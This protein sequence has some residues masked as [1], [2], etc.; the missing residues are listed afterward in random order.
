MSREVSSRDQSVTRTQ[1]PVRAQPD[2]S[3]LS[4]EDR[5]VVRR[6]L[7][8]T[9]EQKPIAAKGMQQHWISA[10]PNVQMA[11]PGTR[12]TY[13]VMIGPEISASD[14]YYTY[15][16]TCYNDPV[17]SKAIGA[18]AVVTGP[19]TPQWSATWAFPGRHR[20]VC[21]VQFHA[22]QEGS[23]GRF[24]DSVP[25]YIEYQQAVRAESNLLTEEMA[26][27]PDLG[28]PGD[29]LRLL[30]GFSD[31]LRSAEAQP[32]SAPVD[33]GTREGLDRQIAGLSEKL[34]SSE[35]KTRYP[36]SAVHV[37]SENAAVSRLNVFLARTSAKPGDE[38]WVLVD[39]TNPTD[40]RLTGEYTGTGKNAREA[41]QRAIERWDGDNRYPAGLLRVEVPG[42][43]GV[44]LEEEFRTDGSS[45]WDSIADFFNQVGLWAGVTSLA[46]AVVLSVAPEPALSKAAAVALWTA[47]LA[48]TTA[49]SIDL[50]QRHAE[51][52]S[53][54]MEDALDAVMIVGN[55]LGARCLLGATVRGLSLQGTRMGTA[56][57]IGR[58]GTDAAQGILL[59]A[60]YLGEYQ[61]ISREPD[62]KRRTDRLISLLQR[63]ATTGG[64][65]ILSM[66]GNKADLDALGAT[67]VDLTQ[68][69]DPAKCIDIPP[70]QKPP[71][72]E[73]PK[74]PTVEPPKPPTVEP[75]KTPD[76]E[77]AIEPRPDVTSRQIHPPDGP[78]PAAPT[79]EAPPRM[80]PIVEAPSAKLPRKINSA[81][82]SKDPSK[83]VY[84]VK[85]LS[86]D[87]ATMAE[88]RAAERLASEGHDVHFRDGFKQTDLVVDGELVDVKHL[89]QTSIKSA[90]HRAHKQY[91]TTVYID[92]T[93]IGLTRAQ[94]QEAIGEMNRIA[95]IHPGPMANVKRLIIVLSD[96]SYYIHTR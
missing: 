19:R 35:G 15:E 30:Q 83:T 5:A 53:T 6:L 22:K 28:E 52:M 64:L 58:F 75:V 50:L 9:A 51:G 33:P 11:V 31:A 96:N 21:R 62:R 80:A 23:P 89:D 79:D 68:L 18:L 85:K 16:W 86:T 72:V 56:V 10:T 48:G 25:E 63:A 87:P 40:R 45:S 67:K 20:V 60:E 29:Q 14:S 78:K 84:E 32:G 47:I 42:S 49:T 71:M 69:G 57:V 93:T 36:V 38:T 73:P 70:S 59:S 26:H 92:G 17:T 13:A 4:A 61:E 44:A 2:V 34:E 77:A 76:G 3:P 66:R 81:R 90:V 8:P 7:R 82:S 1:G 37:A 88:V 24:E 41:I 46:A 39:I 27:A 43:A 91:S 54:P 74:P 95:A 94:A 55:I 65:L 12:I